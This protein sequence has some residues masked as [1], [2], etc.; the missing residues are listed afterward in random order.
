MTKAIEIDFCDKINDDE[1]LKMKIDVS[2][3]VIAE[4]NDKIEK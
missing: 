2:V 4:K 1:T 3:F